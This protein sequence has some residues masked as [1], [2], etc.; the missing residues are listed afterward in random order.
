MHSQKRGGGVVEIPLEELQN[1]TIAET[2]DNGE[3][4]RAFIAFLDSEPPE[5]RDIFDKRYLRSGSIKSI[6]AEYGYSKNKVASL[7][8]R[9]RKR[10]R[11]KLK[12]EGLLK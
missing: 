3:I 11:M 12:S 8:Y 5:H 1:I 10:L 4:T 6:A 7:L 2:A 9:M